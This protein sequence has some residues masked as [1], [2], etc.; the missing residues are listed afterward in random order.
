MSY[1][2]NYCRREE[3][4]FYKPN[5]KSFHSINL[6]TSWSQNRGIKYFSR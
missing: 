4:T 2:S 5:F 6:I 1:N 3:F